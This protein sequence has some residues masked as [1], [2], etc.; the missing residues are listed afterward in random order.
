MPIRL[1]ILSAWD[2]IR[3]MATVTRYHVTASWDGSDLVSIDESI[4]RGLVT[5]AEARAGWKWDHSFDRAPDRG[6]VSLWS[7]LA[8][9]QGWQVEMGGEIL[10]VDVEVDEQYVETTEEGHPAVLCCVPSHQVRR[11]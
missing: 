7:T 2:Y 4:R 8:E 5:E 11:V 6:Y 3:G 9:A 1:D 10:A